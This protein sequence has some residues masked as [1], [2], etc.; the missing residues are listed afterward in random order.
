MGNL[1]PAVKYLRRISAISELTCRDIHAHACPQ[2]IKPETAFCPTCGRPTVGVSASPSAAQVVLAPGQNTLSLPLRVVGQAKVVVRARVAA[3]EPV[4]FKTREGVDTIF[5]GS[6]P[7]PENAGPLT[8]TLPMV[9][10]DDER[11]SLEVPRQVP[12]HLETLDGPPRDIFNV[13]PANRARAWAPLV[14]QVSSPRPAKLEVAT[15]VLLL[16]GRERERELELINSGD[17][18][19]QLRPPVVPVG[20]EISARDSGNSGEWVLAPGARKVW[21]VRALSQAPAGA[22]AMALHNIAGVE[23]GKIT[24]LVPARSAL[25]TRTRYVVGVDFG[26]SG[27]SIYQRDGRDDNQKAVALLDVKARAGV[28]DP[29]RFPTV[30]YVSFKNGLESGFYIGYEALQKQQQK[31]GDAPGLFVREIKSLLRTDEEPFVLQFGPNYRVDLLLRRFLQKLREQII[32]PQLEGGRT[33][34]VAW[35]FS[36]PVLD[37]HAGGSRQLFERQKSRLEN[38]IRDAGTIKTGDELEFFTEPF[39]AA[40]Y[41]L[42]GHG[43]YRYPRNRGPRDGDWAC[44]FDSGGGT[45]D[46]VLGRLRLEQGQMRFEEVRAL[47]GYQKAGEQKVTTFGG[48]LLT[49]KT[50]IYLS[51]WQRPGEVGDAQAREDRSYKLVLHEVARLSRQGALGHRDER[52]VADDLRTIAALAPDNEEIFMQP[53]VVLD[54][55][56]KTNP[57]VEFYDLWEDVERFKRQLASVALPG[58]T[59]N[60]PFPSR[61]SDDKTFPVPIVRREFDEVVVNRR[62]DAMSAAMQTQI[63]GGEDVAAPAEVRWVFGVGGN[64]RVRRVQDW[65]GE[66]FPDRNS[67]Q[68]LTVVSGGLADESDRMLAVAG[69]AVWANK[70]SRDNTLPYSIRVEGAGETIFEAQA[71]VPLSDIEP[72]EKIYQMIYGHHIELRCVLSGDI[73]GPNGAVPFEGAVGRFTLANREMDAEAPAHETPMRNISV[74]IGLEGRTLRAWSDEAGETREVFA[75]SF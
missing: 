9:W 28:D 60:L 29:K 38:A 45:T 8:I 4:R 12:L 66:F 53:K 68:D 19:L 43:N 16:S 7:K 5:D 10:T 46:V 64:C 11:P 44:I 33:A 32:E 73:A 56:I 24:M 51:V 30:L 41:L 34:S 57:W 22:T 2:I 54:K 72:I 52:I 15:E 3:A 14:L 39:C 61:E 25:A 18:P 27:T 21:S 59:V 67:V 37:S 58:A 17:S 35:N 75:F 20:F 62:L 69:G 48:E 50:A 49:R 70:A 26:T 23:L 1:F 63:F 40:V 6:A 55:K 13:E 71:Y 47:G 36:L 65:L 74:R 42:L 31:E